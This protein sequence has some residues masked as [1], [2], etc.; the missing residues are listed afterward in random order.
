MTKQE[1]TRILKVIKTQK[2]GCPLGHQARDF[3]CPTQIFGNG[4]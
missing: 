4:P 3:S 2:Y 1:I